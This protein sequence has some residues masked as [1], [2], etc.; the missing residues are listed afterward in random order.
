M[1]PWMLTKQHG[2][3]PPC[4]DAAQAADVVRPTA[5][6]SQKLTMTLALGLNPP[7]HPYPHLFLLQVR[8]RC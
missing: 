7:M 4:A 2:T 6:M 5:L 1:D 3:L 8:A